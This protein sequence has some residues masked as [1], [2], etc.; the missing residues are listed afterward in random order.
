MKAITV[1]LCSVISS[2]THQSIHINPFSKTAAPGSRTGGPKP[3]SVKIVHTE[4]LEKNNMC[5][6]NV[7]KQHTGTREINNLPLIVT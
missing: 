5:G 6:T 4:I 7:L 3:C 2:L 1:R